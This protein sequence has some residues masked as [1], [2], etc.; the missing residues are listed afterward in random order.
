[1]R[2]M[3]IIA[4]SLFLA[5]N[6]CVC[7]EVKVGEVI[8]AESIPDMVGAEPETAYAEGALGGAYIYFPTGHMK[9]GDD[10]KPALTIR[11]RSS[12]GRL[13]VRARVLALSNGTDSFW[14]RV[15][16]MAWQLSGIPEKKKWAWRELNL[17][18]FMA[19]EHTFSIVPREPLRLDALEL[20]IEETVP[21]PYHVTRMNCQPSQSKPP[22]TNPPVL[23]WPDVG[24]RKTE[25]EW[26]SDA[27]FPEA[28][29]KS[30]VIEGD[31]FYRLPDALGPGKYFW[32]FRPAG[33][34]K[35]LMMN[36][37]EITAG[38]PKFIVPKESEWIARVPKKHPRIYIR[39]EDVPR[40][41]ALVKGKLKEE[42]A[43]RW[44]QLAK[45]I[46]QE[47][48]S[49]T[50][51]VEKVVDYKTKCK[52]R[53]ASKALAT[54]QSRAVEQFAVAYLLTGDERFGQEAKRRA[55][56]L[57]QWDP[58]GFTS[59]KV[60]DFA[61]GWTLEYC[62]MAYDYCYDLFTP[63]ERTRLRDMLKARAEQ[64]WK[65]YHQRIDRHFLHAHGW[66]HIIPS[67]G[68]GALALY[69]EV[70][71]AEEWFKYFVNIW[72]CIYPPWS[73]TD[74]GWANGIG[75]YSTA[76]F[77]SVGMPQLIKSATG[78]DTMEKPW[79][80]NAARFLI[81]GMPPGICRP[82]FGD[83]SPAPPNKRHAFLMDYYA[84]RYADPQA[85][86]Y[87]QNCGFP[88]LWSINELLAVLWSEMPRP[89]PK[90]PMDWPKAECFPDIGWV[91]SHTDITN[92]KDDITFA[93]KSS[94][95]GSYSHMH[96]DQN[97]FV[98][99]IGGKPVCIDSGYYI[100]YGDDH[101]KGWYILTKAHN[102]ILIDGEGQTPHSTEAY[103]R[104]TDFYT[105]ARFD[106]YCGDATTA[107]PKELGL[108]RF[109]RHVLYVR[110]DIFVI[111]DELE[112]DHDAR[113]D[114][115]L[116]T[117]SKMTID[118]RTRTVL[119]SEE[120]GDVSVQ[121]VRPAKLSFEQTDQFDVPAVNWRGKGWRRGMKPANQ[122]HMK[123]W[124]E[125]GKRKSVRF[126]T[127][128]HP[129]HK[130]SQSRI[131]K[132]EDLS[133]DEIC[134]VRIGLADE[135]VVVAFRRDGKRG[136]VAAGGY[137]ADAFAFAASEK[138]YCVVRGSSLKRGDNPLIEANPAGTTA[139]G[140]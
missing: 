13:A 3:R 95:F 44:R 26:S 92:P 99:Q 31:V 135:D 33:T 111:Y 137:E 66:Q 120:T 114:W 21:A 42:L 126:L 36:S 87:V 85:A 1:M 62:A 48:P 54:R 34:E 37:F 58:K 121:F 67:F 5:I 102:S 110:P 107:Y 90:P 84:R 131:T 35:W 10:L 57:C 71:G 74:G 136:K 7:Q 59:H 12:A 68:V 134:A 78:I 112:A 139:S 123:A 19:G 82:S 8:E 77:N 88:R 127:V 47:L 116:H 63:E 80:K 103:G 38:T 9:A 65:S 64:I 113:F 49:D 72:T 93:F 89:D 81:Y 79:H 32:R 18:L 25:I 15:D 69:G 118:P 124:P 133:T 39:P 55:L 76:M 53:W 14:Y 30:A 94:P 6:I 122:W 132:I 138:G 130:D 83:G 125:K 91:L 40:I 52:R 4:A 23:F 73:R 96:A 60:S 101:F 97:S 24:Q 46:G 115:L 105:S 56:H 106:Y 51:Q 129:W 128:L 119:V 117:Y 108:K 61:N 28:A 75:Y 109:K 29:T 98:L 100:A 140:P 41:R 50:S 2:G 17:I 45:R 86:W 70:P 22:M 43:G 11:F 104:I 27:A 16:G 20:R